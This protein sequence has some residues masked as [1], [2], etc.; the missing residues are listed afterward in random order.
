MAT[1]LMWA[2]DQTNMLHF[3]HIR[4]YVHMY[5]QYVHMYI[6]YVRMYVPLY[7]LMAE[8]IV[9]YVYTLHCTV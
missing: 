1:I 4:T 7:S 6:Q 2:V 5:I 9:L 8:Y 3:M